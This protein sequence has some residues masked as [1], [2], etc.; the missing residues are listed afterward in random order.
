MS[1][2]Q[3]VRDTARDIVSGKNPRE[4][5]NEAVQKTVEG[6]GLDPGDFIAAREQG[7]STGTRIEARVTSLH[8]AGEALNRS[9]FES[10]PAGPVHVIT[11]MV[12]P[13]GRTLRSMARRKFARI[14]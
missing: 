5:V 9:N 8:N 3:S 1:F 13:K 11:P 12:M 10:G 6:F 14:S 7:A 4:A 2:T